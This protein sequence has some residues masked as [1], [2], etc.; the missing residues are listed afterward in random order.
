M[1][2][3]LERDAIMLSWR[4]DGWPCV[5]LSENLPDPRVRDALKSR[6]LHLRLFD[7]GDPGLH[8]VVLA[9]V[10]K[11]DGTH[12][13]CGSAASASLAES[14][15]KAALEAIMAY[16]VANARQHPVTSISTSADHIVYAHRAGA[17]VVDWYE[18]QASVAPREVPKA[19]RCLNELAS[20][21]AERFGCEPLVTHLSTVADLEVIRVLVPG[22][23]RKEWQDKLRFAAAQRRGV[24]AKV[25]E[26]LTPHPFG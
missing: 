25:R 3:V 22:V 10:S 7:V 13:T 21:C 5:R 26:N 16:Y 23:M 19:P 17:Q 15:T 20:R 2:E 9:V 18:R 11:R 4:V 6:R 1:C 12:A 14:A 8:P 24:G